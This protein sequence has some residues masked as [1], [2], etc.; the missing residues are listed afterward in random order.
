MFQEKVVP[1]EIGKRDMREKT[2]DGVGNATISTR[3]R[4][5]HGE[6]G[7]TVIRIRASKNTLVPEF[8]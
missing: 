3:H 1:G 2:K 5:G 6:M 4:K 8:G 7:K